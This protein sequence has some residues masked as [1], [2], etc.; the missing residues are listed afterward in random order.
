M[1][2]VHCIRFAVVGRDGKLRDP[3]PQE[4][5]LI[6]QIPPAIEAKGA[7]CASARDSI[8]SPDRPTTE[9]AFMR[10]IVK[11]LVPLALVVACGD[12]G[13]NEIGVHYGGGFVEDKSFQGMIR[14]GS[15]AKLVGFGDS[16]YPYR[17]DQR[18][19]IGRAGDG[20]D[21]PEVEFVSKDNMR[22][23]A[24][25]D[26]YFTLKHDE[27]TLRR[28]H[29][30]IGL[31]TRAY[32]DEGW[33]TALRTYFDPSIDRAVDA[34]GL[35]FDWRP[36]RESEQVRADFADKAAR[37]FTD[38]LTAATGG[39]YFCSPTY[40]K[41]Q[42]DCG[43]ISFAIGQPTPVDPRV[44]EAI[45]LEETARTQTQSLSAEQARAEAEARARQVLIDQVGPEVYACI[46]AI[47]AAERAGAAPPPCIPSGTAAPVV[48]VR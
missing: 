9:G 39:N 6:D 26:I 34:V 48:P 7:P 31:K 1:I 29:E 36:L 33:V 18:S 21:R 41:P 4:Q 19:W 8:R 5:G 35:T 42:D 30:E 27:D 32:E 11:F 40:N 44:V 12:T 16:V 3:T 14:P 46:E 22:M 15:T 45:E 37:Q 2:C 28:F 23:H 47:R 20:G 38:L 17:I 13:A 24:P 43:Q 10:K 25:I